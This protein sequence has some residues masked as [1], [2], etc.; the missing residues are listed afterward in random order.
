MALPGGH[1][2]VALTTNFDDL[3]ADA[4]YLYSPARPLVIHH[5]SLAAFIRPTRSR[6]LI[7]KLHG[8][9]RLSPQN[10]SSE[11]ARLK[12]QLEEHV[13]GLLHDRGLIFLGYGGRDQGIAALLEGLADEALPFG[14][15]WISRRRPSGSIQ[16]W[17]EAREA[18]WVEE[19]DFDEMMLL[20]RDSFDLHHPTPQRFDAVF[21][22]YRKTYE[23]LS[24]RIVQW[25]GRGSQFFALKEAVRRA[26]EGAPDWWG[27]VLAAKRAEGESLEEAQRVYERGLDA[28][29]EPRELLV[30]YAAFLARDQKDFDEA[31]RVY[32]RAIDLY[33]T[34]A[35]VLSNYGVFL[36]RDR[37]DLDG[38]ERFFELAIEAD[39]THAN[40]LGNNAGLLFARGMVAEAEQLATRALAAADEGLAPTLELEIEFYRLANG[41]LEGRTRAL[42]RIKTL[43]SSGARSPDWDLSPNL[44]RASEMERTDLEHLTTLADVITSSR[45]LQDLDDW[46]AW[47]SAD[48]GGD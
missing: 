15:Y 29:N 47:R 11:T 5:E 14:I 13:P 8:D 36:A 22:Q 39:P 9:N 7:V 1:F 32:K 48:P 45:Q 4:M 17:L 37:K 10:T 20:L 31:E 46:E 12:S 35:T 3:A 24:E 42:N 27:V 30:H 43:L 21:E 26:D 18:V 44:R 33:P 16:E 2:N 34:Y 40:A 38:G 19:S 25:A 28:L 41:A 23:Q 6:P